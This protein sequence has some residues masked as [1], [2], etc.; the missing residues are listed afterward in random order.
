MNIMKYFSSKKSRTKKPKTKRKST[1]AKDHKRKSKATKRRRSKASK[2]RVS[3]ASK[4]RVSKSPK[5]RVSKAHKKRVSRFGS[6]GPG[7][8]GPVSFTTDVYAPY[9]NSKEPFV[10]PP[11]WFLPN[12]G[13][14]GKPIGQN[15][16]NYQSPKM[17]YKY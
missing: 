8:V 10:N 13:S 4:K 7:Y 9:F 17:L 3:K 16:K 12:P 15:S 1:T 14:V 11:E 6:K 2:K 5:K